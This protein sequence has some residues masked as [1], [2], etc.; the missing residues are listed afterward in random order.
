MSR[1]PDKLYETLS[2]SFRFCDEIKAW[3]LIYYFDSQLA[4]IVGLDTPR[5]IFL[6]ILR[7]KNWRSI[8][9]FDSQL[10]K[11]VGLSNP[12]PI[13]LPILG[14][15]NRKDSR[16]IIGK[17]IG[18]DTGFYEN[19]LNLHDELDQSSNLI[20]LVAILLIIYM[21][22]V[23]NHL[24]NFRF[25]LLVTSSIDLVN[26]RLSIPDYSP[27]WWFISVPFFLVLITSFSV[28]IYFALVGVPIKL[29]SRFRDTIW[30]ETIC[31]KTTI[32]LLAELSRDDVLINPMKRKFLLSRM[33]RLAVVTKLIPLTNPYA[34]IRNKSVDEHFEKISNFI[35]ERESWIYSPLETT[36]W[37]LRNDFFEL[38][39]VYLS[40]SY[41]MF[42]ASLPDYL[43]SR[44]KEKA[45]KTSSYG[46]TLRSLSLLVPLIFIGLI[47]LIP[48]DKLPF[49][50][51]IEPTLVLIFISWFLLSVDQLLNLGVVKG[52]ID[53]AKGIKDLE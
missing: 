14:I 5:P 53:L 32:F 37:D 40:G 49:D 48:D 7:I 4:K 10:A 33:E 16:R 11:I 27:I 43:V 9:Y 36:L 28:F 52:L 12:C 25:P 34:R 47:I 39:S 8:Y 23:I 31:A 46:Q 42:S 6:P 18:F 51:A 2:G 20:N 22:F 44:Q 24:T 15:K 38:A 50:N 29:L 30:S 1:Y 41:G 3:R 17:L 13:F 35:R 21:A 19:R 26:Q 45:S